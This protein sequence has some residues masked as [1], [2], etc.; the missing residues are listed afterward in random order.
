MTST[1]GRD[2]GHGVRV[3]PGEGGGLV[4]LSESTDLGWRPREPA[5][6]GSAVTWRE[7][8]FEVVRREPWRRGAR[9]SLEPWPDSE[10]MRVVAPLDEATVAAAAEAGR[11]E[12][13]AT[14]LRP[15]AWLAAPLLGFATASWQRRWRDDWGFPA[16][17]ATS[18]SAVLEILLGAVCMIELISSFGAGRSLFEWIP[19]P[20]VFFGLVLFVEGAVRLAQ[21]FADAEPVGTLIGLLVSL[22]VPRRP[23]EAPP[24]PGPAV[25]TLD[26]SAGQLELRSPIV[27]RDWEGPGLLPY[28]GELWA[29][30]S[31]RQLGDVWIYAF[32]RVEPPPGDPAPLL[33]LRPAPPRA[34]V[35]ARRDAPG[36]VRSV[37]LSIACTLAPA[38]H[39]VRWAWWT[40]V[41]ATGFTLF[42]AT[43][44]LAGGLV[45][46]SSG[47]EG[48]GVALLTNLAVVVE[49]AVRLG[50]VVLRGE[51]LGSLLGLALGPLLDRVLPE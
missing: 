19:R 17:A 28:R 23:D 49:G 39:Q 27:R 20:L 42:G 5:R 29:L 34:E 31:A 10:V 37:L 7:A 11:R 18:S 51:P 13:R 43:V 36:P 35:P 40:G 50:W 44:E 46:L 41:R 2:L 32:A 9:W 15:G 38:R 22:A 8:V 47:Q 30:S 26:H 14:R 24:P 12:A 4:V 25:E 21:V 1:A 6:A 16:V 48:G 33:R 3:L 45:N